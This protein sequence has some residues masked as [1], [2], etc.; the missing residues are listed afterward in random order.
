MSD[1]LVSKFEFKTLTVDSVYNS[2][3]RT[4]TFKINNTPI[5]IRTINQQSTDYQI[6]E[7]FKDDAGPSGDLYIFTIKK[8]EN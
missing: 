7:N 8:I 4:K 5:D 6:Y 1:I 2:R 3:R